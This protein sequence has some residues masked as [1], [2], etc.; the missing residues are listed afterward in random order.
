[1]T[2]QRSL[3]SKAYDRSRQN[4]TSSKRTVEIT[5]LRTSNRNTRRLGPAMVSPSTSQPL[6][7]SPSTQLRAGPS[8]KLRTGLSKLVLRKLEGP[9]VSS[10]GPETA[11][12]LRT[13][14]STELRTGLSKP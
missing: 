5:E 8:T 6:V 1:M 12:M 2:C 9:V 14:P 3:Y 7:L 10:V 4:G 13:G 11:G